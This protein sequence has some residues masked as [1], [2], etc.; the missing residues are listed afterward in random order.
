[1]EVPFDESMGKAEEEFRFIFAN[2]EDTER[3]NKAKSLYEKNLPSKVERSSLPKIPKIIHQIWLG[4]NRPPSYFYVYQEKWQTLHPHWEYHLWSEEEL[5]EL[6]LVNWDLVEKSQN[7][8]EKSDI[9]RGD[10]LE[11]FGGVY[12][13]VDMEPF[14]ALDEFHEKYDF[15]AGME[16]PHK[17]ST[18]QN[19]VWVG[20]SLIASRPHHPIIEKWRSLV[21]QGWDETEKKYS[22]QVDQVI[23]HTYFPFTR[24]VME[25]VGRPGTVDMLFPATY[26]YPLS[27]AYA[28]KRRSSLR[29]LR[30]KV[31]DFLENVHLRRP[32]PFSRIYPETIAVHYWGNTW[33]PEMKVQIKEMQRLIDSSRK[34]IHSLRSKMKTLEHQVL[35]QAQAIEAI[36]SKKEHS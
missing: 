33:L 1:M 21:R 13:D 20:I 26:F 17:I 4:P 15:Y 10:L 16:H 35:V 18:T 19:R 9:I 28:S 5:E 29:S 34:E 2:S 8:A 12:I 22:V 14:R 27:P 31:Y 24:A 7:W 6:H 25:E 36:T 11:R 3:Y 32:R 23:N 30:E